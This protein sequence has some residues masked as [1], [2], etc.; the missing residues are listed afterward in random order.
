[1]EVKSNGNMMD[2]SNRCAVALNCMHLLVDAA[3]FSAIRPVVPSRTH[4]IS[5]G[6]KTG[7]MSANS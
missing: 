3:F 2:A 7:D 6:P 1:V 4:R 5:A